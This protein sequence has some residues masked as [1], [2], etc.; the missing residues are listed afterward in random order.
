MISKFSQLL[1]IGGV[2]EQHCEN[3]KTIFVG[4]FHH[5]TSRFVSVSKGSNLLIFHFKRCVEEINQIIVD[6]KKKEKKN[7]KQRKK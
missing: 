5:E 7:A 6:F 3:R 2:A 1:N 4:S